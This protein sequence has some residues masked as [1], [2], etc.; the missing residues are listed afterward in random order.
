MVSARVID[1]LSRSVPLMLRGAVITVKI[2]V[3][4]VIIGAIFGTLFGIMNSKKLRLPGISHVINAYTLVMRGTPI[5][6]QI[7]IVYFALPDLVGVNLSPFTAGVVALGANSVAYVGEI[8]RAGINSIPS[9]QWDAAYVLGYSM[10]ETLRIIILPQ[11]LRNVLP[12]LTNEL[13]TLVKETSVL[14]TIG[15]VELTRVSR[16]IIARELD[17]MTIYLAAAVMYLV[18]TTA[19]SMVAKRLEKGFAHD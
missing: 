4:A 2:S 19:I 17:P 11:M 1:L 13:V 7:L 14:A 16:D 5:Y 9:G 18:M 8:V 12:A 6:V 3:C 15:L 10:P